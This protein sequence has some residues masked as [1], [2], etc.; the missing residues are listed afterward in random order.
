MLR[1]SVV[2]VI[3]LAVFHLTHGQVLARSPARP[4]ARS[5]C[6]AATAHAPPR[7]GPDPVAVH[8]TVGHAAA[9]ARRMPPTGTAS[10]PSVPPRLR[11][12]NPQPPCRVFYS[13]RRPPPAPAAAGSVAKTRAALVDRS[14]SSGF[15]CAGRASVRSACSWRARAACRSGTPRLPTRPSRTK[16]RQPRRARAS[17]AVRRCF[18]DGWRPALRTAR[19]RRARAS[20]ALRRARGALVSQGAARPGQAGGAARLAAARR[21]SHFFALVSRVLRL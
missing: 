1:V 2:W 8:A 10:A 14:A 5:P 12:R 18:A 13:K 20:A 4:L 11:R 19:E 15:R 6:A 3:E 17:S 9:C 16:P 7:G 21:G